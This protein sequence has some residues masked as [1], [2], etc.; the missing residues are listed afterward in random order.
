MKRKPTFAPYI[1]SISQHT[2]SADT[3]DLIEDLAYE[4]RTLLGKC[5]VDRKTR[6]ECVALIRKATTPN[7]FGH[8]DV[9]LK[10]LEEALGTFAPPYTRFG[11]ADS[12]KFGFWPII[13]DELPRTPRN[14][15]EEWERSMW[16]NGDCFRV[17]DHGNVECG[18]YD[19]RGRW[20]EYWSCV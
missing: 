14:N 11:Q 8:V 18:R 6:K 10:A 3:A 4:L 12:C 1:G 5:R 15:Q 9:M 2:Q 16:G 20:H 7:S 17:N 13:D 19:K